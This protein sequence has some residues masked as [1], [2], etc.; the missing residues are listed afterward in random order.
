MFEERGKK[1]SALKDEAEAYIYEKY[2]V[3]PEH[4]WAQYPEYATFKEEVSKKWFA[5]ILRVERGKL[6]PCGDESKDEEIN[7]INLKA[8]TELILMLAGT[9]GFFPGYH[10]NKRHWLTIVLDG[11]VTLDQIKN[12]I[13]NSYRIISDTPSRRIYEAVKKIPKGRVATYGQVAAMAGNAKMSRAVGNALHKNPDPQ[14]IPCFRVVN[15]KGELSGEFAFGGRGEQEKLLV[16]DG[17]EV[18]NGKVDLGKYGI[19][20]YDEGEPCT[21]EK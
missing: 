14:N 3:T 4:P 7:I 21:T 18:Q 6:G 12:H 10:M 11:T 19:V 16:A 20:I 17:I 15:S 8:K 5:C 9:P 2:R 13:D 1:G